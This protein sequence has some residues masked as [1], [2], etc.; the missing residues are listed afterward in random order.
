MPELRQIFPDAPLIARTGQVNAWDNTDFAKAVNATGR[1]QLIVAGLVT[2][3]CVASL[4]LSAHNE[5]YKVFIVTDASGTF[6]A[7]ARHAAWDSMSAAGAQLVT[8]FC[9]ASDL[10]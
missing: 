6:N 5:G 3:A 4:A 9:L 8:L 2:E 10:Y 1:K 7:A